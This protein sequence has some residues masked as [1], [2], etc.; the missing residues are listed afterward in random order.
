MCLNSFLIISIA[1]EGLTFP[2]VKKSKLIIPF[3]GKVWKLIWLSA[4][5]ARIVKPWGSN[6]YLDIFNIVTFAA[7]AISLI[8]LSYTDGSYSFIVPI[9]SRVICSPTLVIIIYTP[10]NLTTE[11]YLNFN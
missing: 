9:I 11:F 7:S 3:S 1:I 6:V 10:T 2:H 4:N 8:T 5:K